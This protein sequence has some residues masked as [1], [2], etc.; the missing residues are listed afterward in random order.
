MKP[1]QFSCEQIFIKAFHLVTF[2]WLTFPG[3]NI[4]WYKVKSLSFGFINSENSSKANLSNIVENHAHMI[5]IKQITIYCNPFLK[6]VDKEFEDQISDFDTKNDKKATQNDPFLEL[7]A[8][9]W[10]GVFLSVVVGSR[11]QKFDAN[12]TSL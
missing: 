10:G 2:Q 3:I 7:S 12:T 9:K 8:C 1:K 4:S 6:A 5:S 11:L